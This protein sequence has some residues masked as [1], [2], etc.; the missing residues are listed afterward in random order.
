MSVTR[1]AYFPANIIYP[2]NA[3]A[4][5]QQAIELANQNLLEGVVVGYPGQLNADYSTLL[6]ICVEGEKEFISVIDTKTPEGTSLKKPEVLAAEIVRKAQLHW[7]AKSVHAICISRLG[8]K[9]DTRRL[10]SHTF[11]VDS[12]DNIYVDSLR[13]MTEEE[14][15]CVVVARASLLHSSKIKRLIEKGSHIFVFDADDLRNKTVMWINT[16]R[17]VTRRSV[18]Q[19]GDGY[20]TEEE[21][22][23]LMGPYRLLSNR[24]EKWFSNALNSWPFSP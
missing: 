13:L 24:Q 20:W 8:A 18:V 5:L 17:M 4:V 11:V 10:S 7:A 23:Y 14:G 3:C 19:C 22:G 21:Q 15:G 16:E 9:M 12:K 6:Y 2:I 1:V